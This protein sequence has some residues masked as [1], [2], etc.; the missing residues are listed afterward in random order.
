MIRIVNKRTH[1]PT[2]NDFYIGRGSPL[3]NPYTSKNSPTKAD[4][5]CD[6]P[7]QSVTLFE[8][9]LIKKIKNKDVKIC[10]ELNK[11]W[12]SAKKGDVNLVCYCAK[13]NEPFI[14]HG[15]IV[16]KIIEQKL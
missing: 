13:I 3:G 4:F 12:K 11:I 14:C 5:T 7:E 16:K 8:E 1:K 10:N 2:K 6:T 15:N 9:Y